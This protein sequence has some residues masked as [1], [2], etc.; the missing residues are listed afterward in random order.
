MPKSTDQLVQFL[1]QFTTFSDDEIQIIHEQSDIREYPKGTIL[2]REGEQ[3][4]NRFLVLQ[5]CVR[6]YNINDG[7]EINT[8]FF[9][10]HDLLMPV[11]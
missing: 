7:E 1:S 5:G 6:S 11:S 2:L 3:A 8:E 9:I 4:R 10:E